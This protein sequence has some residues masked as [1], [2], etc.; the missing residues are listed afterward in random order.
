MPKLIKEKIKELEYSLAIS[1]AITNIFPLA[2]YDSYGQFSA[3]EVN[4]CYNRTLFRSNDFNLSVILFYDFS[5]MYEGEIHKLTVRCASK[6]S[7]E[8]ICCLWNRTTHAYD[9][10]YFRDYI[11]SFKKYKVRDDILDETRLEIV[12]YVKKHHKLKINSSNLEPRLKKLL[13]FA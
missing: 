1:K 2:K 11:G 13:A 12:K 10:L 9:S 7:Y 6:Q 8:I 3:P 4:Q 5:F